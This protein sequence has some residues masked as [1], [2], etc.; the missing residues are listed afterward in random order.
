MAP[1]KL[2]ADAHSKKENYV[3]ERDRKARWDPIANDPLLEDKPVPYQ[4]KF[5]RTIVG[6]S[7]C[8]ENDRRYVLC[9]P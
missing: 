6:C 5:T 9:S 7:S 3:L 4:A 8:G 1:V 2:K